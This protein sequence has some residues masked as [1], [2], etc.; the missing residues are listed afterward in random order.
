MKEA[1][2]KVGILI[3]PVIFVE[4][5]E[6]LYKELIIYLDEKLSPKA[7]Q[8]VFFEV[9]FM[10]YSFIHRKINEEAFPSAINLYN[11]DLMTGRG[12][13]KYTYKQELRRRGEEY[14]GG[15]LKKYFPNH[16]IEYFS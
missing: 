15:L 8:N 13:G 3:A 12:K 5:W 2:Y 4:N 6:E 14:I 11:Q 10:T 1:G 7:K 16:R 9:I